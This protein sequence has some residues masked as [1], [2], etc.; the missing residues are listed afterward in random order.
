IREG[1]KDI[2]DLY[3]R[4][5]ATWKRKNITPK[6]HYSEPCPEALTGRQRRKHSPR[7]ATLPPLPEGVDL[8]IEAKDKEQAVFELMRIFKLP[9]F[10]RFNDMIPHVRRD[11]NKPLKPTPKK[12]KQKA[13]PK[14]KKAAVVKDEDDDSEEP[15]PE[16]EPALP[17]IVP[18]EDV[19][20]GGP[21]GRVYWP[22]G[23]EH[24]LRPVKRVIKPK[25]D[26]KA[27]PGKE[28]DEK[29]RI[30]TPAMKRKRAAA[31]AEAEA[32]EKANVEGEELA[33]EV[34]AEVDEGE[35]EGGKGKAREKLDVPKSAKAKAKGN[36]KR[37]K[38]R[39]GNAAEA[40]AEGEQLAAE[41]EAVIDA[42]APK[43]NMKREGGVRRVDEPRPN[44]RQS[45]AKKV[46]YK[47]EQGEEEE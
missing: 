26:R 38:A 14:K 18:D 5:L 25:E 23:Q 20:M 45:R 33:E 27:P 4:I 36:A 24:W 16:L 9:G 12:K 41:V 10:D 37:A 17:E 19:G 8:M 40:E 7:V 44:R 47:E 30:I 13:T 35:G 39:G 46:D 6:M 3:P 31:E 22:P 42:A 21:D 28:L 34:E 1:T 32:A 29:G 15:E 11:E 2:I 43:R